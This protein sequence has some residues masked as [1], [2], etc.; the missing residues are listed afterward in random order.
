MATWP[1]F[2]LGQALWTIPAA[3]MKAAKEHVIPLGEPAMAVLR[4]AQKH[5]QGKVYVFPSVK[6][7]ATKDHTSEKPLS[8]MACLQLLKRMGRQDLT[9]YGF[10]S[11][12]RDWAGDAT[13]HPR[14]VI[15][16]AMSHQLKDLAEAPMRAARCSDAGAI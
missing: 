12:F 5:G 1:E 10:R 13:T 9:V 4:K 7:K 3:R 2:D 15:E 8:N 16:H 14:E 11:S 6:T